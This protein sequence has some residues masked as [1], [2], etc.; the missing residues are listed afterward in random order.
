VQ[1]EVPQVELMAYVAVFARTTGFGVSGPT[2]TL[3]IYGL[4]ECAERMIIEENTA[5]QNSVPNTESLPNRILNL[6]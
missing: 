1:V 3:R 4:L 5:K 2:L 6:R